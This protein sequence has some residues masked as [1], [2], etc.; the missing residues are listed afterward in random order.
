MNHISEQPKSAVI[1]IDLHRGHLDPMVATMPLESSK[2][3]KVIKQNKLFFDKCREMDIPI[4]HLLTLY[5]DKQEILS[6]PFWNKINEDPHHTRKNVAKHNLQ[7]LPGTEIIPELLNERDY[8]VDVK[9]RYNC[10][11]ATDLQFLLRSHGIKRLYVTGV[12]TNSCVL[13]TTVDG[14]CKDFEMVVVEDCVDTMDGEDFHVAALKILKRAFSE[15]QKSEDIIDVISGE[16]K[17]TLS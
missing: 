9:K 17:G 2:A 7:G 8:I 11:E 14:S 12:N 1:A 5:R 10:F 16:P 15:V 4:I 6:N 3:E 13:A